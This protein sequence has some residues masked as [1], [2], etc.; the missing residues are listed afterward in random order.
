MKAF[1]QSQGNQE[2]VLSSGSQ[3]AETTTSSTAVMYAQQCG[4]GGN[5]MAA[6]MLNAQSGAIEGGRSEA[7]SKDNQGAK[8]PEMAAAQGDEQSLNA[9]AFTYAKHPYFPHRMGQVFY[10]R[11]LIDIWPAMD[12]APPETSPG[13]GYFVKPCKT[14]AMGGTWPVTVTPQNDQ[15]YQSPVPHEDYPD[16]DYVI[17]VG[18]GAAKFIE[19]AEQ[20]HV[21][22]LDY[23]WAI[24]GQAVADAINFVAGQEPNIRGT[25]EEAKGATIDA[26]LNEIGNRGGPRGRLRG[27]LE[28]EG[29]L[30]STLAPM[31]D[32]ACIKSQDA[33]DKGHHHT[34]DPEKIQVDNEAKRVVG[35]V[36]EKTLGGPSTKAV[37]NA[38]TIG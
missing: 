26:I 14:M 24:T 35:S 20:Q 32:N 9:G 13:R 12:F 3:S 17:K 1:L 38:G 36:P 11:G 19:G 23:G 33:R 31:M 37:I 7:D 16:Y 25:V 30:E 10:R 29:R 6:E 18:A 5:A 34:G 27:A 2:G 21:D 22:D 15:G 8:A 28:G 4:G